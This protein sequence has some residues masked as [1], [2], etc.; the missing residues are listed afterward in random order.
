MKHDDRRFD[1]VAREARRTLAR[2]RHASPRSFE[3]HRLFAPI[4]PLERRRAH[5]SRLGA[6]A[7]HFGEL[8]GAKALA[9]ADEVNGLEHARLAMPVVSRKNGEPR[10]LGHVRALD[11]AKLPQRE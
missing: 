10:E 1:R 11:V 6:V 5:M 3:A 9:R 7:H 4:A 8:R 2:E